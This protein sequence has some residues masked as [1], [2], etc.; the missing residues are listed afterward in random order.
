[1]KTL[2]FLLLAFVAIAWADDLISPNSKAMPLRLWYS[3][4]ESLNGSMPIN[5]GRQGGM[6]RGVVSTELISMNED[7]LWSDSLLDRVNPSAKD[8]LSRIKLCLPRETSVTQLLRQT[9]GSPVFLPV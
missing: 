5:N 7:S 4:S 6:V 3:T 1:M 8:S 2:S 9:S